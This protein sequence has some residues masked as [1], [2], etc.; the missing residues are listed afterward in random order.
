MA[1]EPLLFNLA[2]DAAGAVAAHT[3]GVIGQA[4]SFADALRRAAVDQ[5][6]PPSPEGNHSEAASDGSLSQT[7]SVQNP[8]SEETH[9]D[10]VRSAVEAAQQQLLAIFRKF[11]ITANL[12]PA[13]E[14]ALQRD[15][16]GN[17]KSL[18]DGPEGKQLEELIAG[19]P[20]TLKLITELI[21]GKRILQAAEERPA[22]FDAY[23]RDPLSAVAQFG[24]LFE[25][26][27]EP[28]LLVRPDAGLVSVEY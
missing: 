27:K 3:V 1:V 5:I 21:D 12:E 10:G 19:N 2:A 13:T 20:Q 11:S 15:G 24:H 28:V 8:P 26:A 6:T 25:G 4:V 23:Q 16:N 22:F 17:V 14:F 9:L 18:G 7:D